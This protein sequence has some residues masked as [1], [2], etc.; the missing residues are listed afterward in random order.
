[1]FSFF[2][3]YD[4]N[5]IKKK[6]GKYDDT[7]QMGHQC[8]QPLSSVLE[9]HTFK[10]PLYQRDYKW[11]SDNWDEL[12]NDIISEKSIFLGTLFLYKKGK[13]GASD[14]E[15]ID[16]QQRITTVSL[17][18]NALRLAFVNHLPNPSVERSIISLN[19]FLKKGGEPRLLLYNDP[20][21]IVNS[22]L[23]YRDVLNY[24]EM[25][26]TISSFNSDLLKLKNELNELKLEKKTI[27][28]DIKNTQDKNLKGELKVKKE[29]ITSKIKE[30]QLVFKELKDKK[31]HSKLYLDNMSYSEINILECNE[32]FYNRLKDYSLK[33]LKKVWKKIQ[34]DITVFTMITTNMN[35]VYDYFRTLNSSGVNLTLSEILKND[36]FKNIKT[37]QIEEVISS[38]EK[39]KKSISDVKS[40]DMESFLLYGLNSMNDLE[41]TLHSIKKSYPI[42]KKN[43]LQAYGHILKK[44]GSINLVKFLEL[45]IK[46]YLNIIFPKSINN[47]M[48][49][50]K[51]YFYNVLDAFNISKPISVFLISARNYSAINHL[52]NIKILT[53]ICLKQSI[54]PF[55]DPK[56]LQSYMNVAHKEF[57]KKTPYS[58]LKK[59]LSE[60]T[61]NFFEDE[62]SDDEHKVLIRN[63]FNNK[64]SKA[65]LA[66][67]DRKKWMVMS[68]T[69]DD[70]GKLS[71]EH[72]MPENQSNF[73]KD[74]SLFEADF[75]ALNNEKKYKRWVGYPGNHTIMTLKDNKKIK[76]KAFVEKLKIYK[77]YKNVMNNI[78]KV[79]VWSLDE[80]EKRNIYIYKE[81]LKLGK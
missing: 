29:A 40:E 6:M 8:P 51:F 19:S 61:N 37:T 22:D 10:V 1:M 71:L 74:P 58:N 31:D 75:E 35:S 59:I 27:I 62:F 4:E 81:F 78:L 45:N 17:L 60:K 68:G 21:R 30:N 18:I 42:S 43:M 70:Y 44:D 56:D 65:F 15:I 55:G 50:E 73:W 47:Y 25:P 64:K 67:I 11:S 53:Y 16:G 49:N 41:S 77:T 9:S 7:L 32:F 23:R 2:Y 57:S 3:N 39:I 36:L 34:N 14:S 24:H 38:F 66:L 80:I 69:Y 33:E 79:K 72:V 12:F 20:N 63:K 52:K 54:K 46:E 5:L 13:I 28:R 48:N 76:D 26:S